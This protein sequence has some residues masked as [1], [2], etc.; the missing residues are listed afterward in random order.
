MNFSSSAEQ[1]SDSVNLKIQDMIKEGKID[2]KIMEN[3]DPNEVLKQLIEQNPELKKALIKIKIFFTIMFLL[4]IVEI[5]SKGFAMWRASKKNSKIWFW[6]L[7][8]T[9]SFGILPILYLIFSKDLS[10]EKNKKIK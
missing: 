8:I 1:I 6:V 2:Y 7:L 3:S 10:K 4:F 5:I 9:F